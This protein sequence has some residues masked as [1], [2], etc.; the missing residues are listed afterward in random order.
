M[1][2]VCFFGWETELNFD[3]KGSILSVAD[4]MWVP[5]LFS[6]QV[7][8]GLPIKASAIQFKLE[9]PDNISR[10]DDVNRV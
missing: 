1:L 5:L 7:P 10:K 3:K 2:S 8:R 6:I 4:W 9:N